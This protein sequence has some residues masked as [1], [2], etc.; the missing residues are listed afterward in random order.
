MSNISVRG[1]NIVTKTI[2]RTTAQCYTYSTEQFYRLYSNK[3]TK[4]HEPNAVRFLAS[5]PS[6]TLPY[7]V[8]S[9]IFFNNI[10][11]KALNINRCTA[12][13]LSSRRSELRL[14]RRILMLHCT[15]YLQLCNRVTCQ[16]LKTLVRNKL[17]DSISAEQFAAINRQFVRTNRPC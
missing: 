13:A 12:V 4:M 17:I 14:N 5:Q 8:F 11:H 7:I 3:T 1:C 9:K 10:N 16:I 15:S 2:Q 6:I